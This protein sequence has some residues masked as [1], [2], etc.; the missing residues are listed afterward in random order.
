MVGVV[1]ALDDYD[2]YRVFTVD[3]SSGATIDV[4]Y[5]KPEQVKEQDENSYAQLNGNVALP[6]AA[7]AEASST[8]GDG[9]P[10]EANALVEVVSRVDIGSVV[11]VK[12]TINTFRSVRQM[13]LERLEIIRDTNAEVRFWRQRTQLFVEVLSKPWELSAEEQQRL[14]REAEGEVED[15]KGRAARRAKRA[16]KQQRR[17]KRHAE[18]IA[19]AYELEERVRERVAEEMRQHGMKLKEAR[20]EKISQAGKSTIP[21]SRVTNLRE[22]VSY[23]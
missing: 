19:K 7:A 11:K 18:K 1:V 3:D 12:G 23:K 5:R 8:K 6:K 4:S 21:N 13:T 14:L 15:T 22:L 2:R 9:T 10:D 16:A 20:E 17:E